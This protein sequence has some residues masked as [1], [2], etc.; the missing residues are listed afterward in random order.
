MGNGRFLS[1]DRLRQVR[2]MDADI[3]GKHAGGRHMNFEVF[4]KDVLNPSRMKRITNV[5]IFLK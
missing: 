2:M 5:H 1:A 3:L 4:K